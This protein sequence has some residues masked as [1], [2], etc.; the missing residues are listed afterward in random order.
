MRMSE[1]YTADEVK[2]Q[3]LQAMGGELG[4]LF[5]HLYNEH[6]WL[7][8]KWGD[9]VVLFAS[10]PERVDLLNM[11]APAFFKLVQDSLW[12]AIL[13]HICRLTDPPEIRNKKNLTLQHLPRLVTPTIQPEI[14][15]L[16]NAALKASSFARDWRNRHIAH[17]D[18]RLVLQETTLPLA[19]ASREGVRMA[20]VAITAVLNCIDHHYRSTTVA[21]DMIASL[22]NAETL[23]HVLREGFEAKTARAERRKSE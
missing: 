21:Y 23:L 4:N 17:R 2:Q 10:R 13:L 5:Y 3:C 15:R 16:V 11:A 20:L 8:W 22:G 6:A 12:E 9:Y 7:C 19:P 1:E 18:L 14:A